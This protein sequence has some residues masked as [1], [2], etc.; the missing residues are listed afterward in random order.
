MTGRPG[1]G[2]VTVVFTPSGVHADVAAPRCSMQRWAV[3]VDLDSTC[4]GGLCGRCQVTPSVGEFA[5]WGIT[6]DESSVSPWTSSEADYKGRRTIEP[7]GRLGCMA[8]ALADVVVD[9][10]PPA[11]CTARSF[12]RRSICPG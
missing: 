6:S 7:G 9:V 10:P 11:R 12:A 2:N 4:G 3:K 5:K 8:T 1:D